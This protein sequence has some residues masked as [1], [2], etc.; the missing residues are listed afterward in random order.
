MRTGACGSGVN[1][2]YG[3]CEISSVFY[4]RGM[5][6]SVFCLKS[7]QRRRFS[8]LYLLLARYIESCHPMGRGA[9]ALDHQCIGLEEA[10]EAAADGAVDQKGSVAYSKPCIGL[11]SKV[12]PCFHRPS[13]FRDESSCLT[14]HPLDH[15]QQTSSSG[16]HAAED[17][18]L[19]GGHPSSDSVNG[20][21]S[22]SGSGGRHEDGGNEG[23]LEVSGEE[24]EAA[25]R[26]VGDGYPSK[27][28]GASGERA[29]VGKCSSRT[30]VL[31][32]TAN[33]DSPSGPRQ[34]LS[35]SEWT[36]K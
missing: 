9:N 13:S 4:C 15:Q 3:L 27:S 6:V 16:R 28:H 25:H 1:F 14:E 12:D 2:E 18:D 31:D 10:P 23:C 19:G 17:K 26:I 22:T 20:G 32:V 34:K 30:N 5:R 33:T 36:A 11:R 7:L 24:G 29:R 21:S 8:L 35:H